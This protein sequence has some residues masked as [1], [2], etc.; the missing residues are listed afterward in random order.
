MGA[1]RARCC[2]LRAATP[3]GEAAEAVRNRRSFFT[4]LHAGHQ[5]HSELN[6][7][8][9]HT[10]SID[11]IL[12]AT[13]HTCCVLTST[14]VLSSHFN[15][16]SRL[17]C[18]ELPEIQSADISRPTL[19]LQPSSMRNDMDGESCPDAAL[20]PIGH[21]QICLPR[22]ESTSSTARRTVGDARR[23]EGWS[24]CIAPASSRGLADFSGGGSSPGLTS[25]TSIETRRLVSAHSS[26][27]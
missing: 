4:Q 11:V 9:A 18:P 14:S 1:P 24:P 8:L 19:P 10:S 20:H 22:A 17:P 21:Q 26:Q 3:S 23:I 5:P 27:M 7:A 2:G 12:P 25:T 15:P 13:A 6:T 16:P